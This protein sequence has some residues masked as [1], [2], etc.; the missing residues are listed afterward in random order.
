MEVR[1][2]PCGLPVPEAPVAQ[3]HFSKRE[4]RAKTLFSSASTGG[5]KQVEAGAQPVSPAVSD[6][7]FEGRTAR[8]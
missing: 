2:C 7:G 1:Q 5:Q 4:A 3:S 8:L 6:A